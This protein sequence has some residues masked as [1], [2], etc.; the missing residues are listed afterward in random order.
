MKIRKLGVEG[1]RSL[2]KVT[3]KPGDLNVL[4]GPN[5]SG[6]SN[7]LRLLRLLGASADKRLA[8]HVQ[9]EGGMGAMLWDGK[10]DKILIRMK[11]IP[12]HVNHGMPDECLTYELTFSQVGQ[13]GSCHIDYELLDNYRWEKSGHYEDPFKFLKRDWSLGVV[14]DPQTTDLQEVP[15]DEI[16]EDETLLS[17]AGGAFDVNE[18]IRLFRSQV[19]DWSIFTEFATGRESAVRKGVISRTEKRLQ[20]DGANLVSVLHTLY[21]TEKDFKTDVDEA[22]QAAFGKD[23]EE[24]VFAPEA[25]QRIQLRLVWKSLKRP[26]SATDLS[27]GTLRFLYLLTILADPNPASLIAIDE[28][29]TGLHPSMQRIIAEFAVAASQR[30][31]V[32]ITTHSPE[33]LDAFDET[34]PTTTVVETEDGETNLRN[35]SGEALAEWVKNYSLGEILRTDEASV[36]REETEE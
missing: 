19:L 12:S 4:I 15:K 6:K 28:P 3:W 29:E 1:Y 20:P 13:T 18:V 2:R 5:A 35:L 33:F 22:M 17:V 30:T 7:L 10:A 34:L 8:K 21:T 16:P 14:I 27:D 26:Q 9:S 11:T 23:F 31:Q 32:V 24:L 25:D 36:I